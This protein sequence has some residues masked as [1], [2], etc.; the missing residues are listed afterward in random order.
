[1]IK[2]ALKS[3]NEFLIK[4]SELKMEAEEKFTP[5]LTKAQKAK[6]IA[7]IILQSL[8]ALICFYTFICSLDL[9]SVAFKLLAGSRIITWITK[10]DTGNPEDYTYP[11]LL[12]IGLIGTAILQSSSTFTSIIVAAIGKSTNFVIISFILKLILTIN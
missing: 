1:M 7:L 2:P 5:P 3:F 8:G 10:D 11:F 4:S 9:M 6:R 12:M